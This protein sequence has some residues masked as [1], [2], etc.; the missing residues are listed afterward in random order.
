MTRYHQSNHQSPIANLQSSISNHLT[1]QSLV[2]SLLVSSLF[3]SSCAPAPTPIAPL[4][5]PSPQPSAAPTETAA[6]EPTADPRVPLRFWHAQPQAALAPL[7]DKF[8]AANADINVVVASQNTNLDL[9][10]N[11]T[12]S[13]G[14]DAQPDVLLTYPTDLAQFAKTGA[15]LPLDDPKLGF[16]ADDM[17]DF[18]PAF[19]D[20]YPQFGIKIYSIGWSRHLQVMYYNSDLL[21]NGNIS[22]PPETW[23]DFT[24]AC[25]AVNKPPD[26]L[27]FELDPN[28]LDFESAVLGRGGGLVTGDGKRVTFDQKPGLDALTWIS[29]TIRSKY[30]VLTTRAFQEQSDFAA[31]KVAFTFDTTLALP[32][33]DKQIKNAGKNFA[34][35]VAVPPRT[36]TPIVMAYGPSLAIVKTTPERQR[37]A[38]TFVQ[39]MLSREYS[40]TWA[41]AANS[42]PARQTAKDNLADNIKSAPSYGQAYNWLRFA[43]AEP[44]MA[45][46]ASVRPIIA[47]AMLSVATGKSLPADALKDAATRANAALGQ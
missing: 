12:A 33:Y 20:R 27:C 4:T 31:G 22:K 45:A 46:W 6:P 47:D 3:L 1:S 18:F 35:G 16:G 42:F 26:V 15:L 34:W 23:D 25:A 7:I 9:V 44:N 39:A 43:R 19:V 17:K 21:K 8:N 2:F 30:A 13:L 29:D 37:A 10:R 32:A 41:M 36:V 11:V 24:K 38:F 40:A 28:A 14:S 5:T